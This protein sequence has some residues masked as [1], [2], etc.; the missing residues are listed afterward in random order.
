MTSTSSDPVVLRDLP[1]ED[2]GTAPTGSDLRSGSWTRLGDG[3][4]V[5]DPVT[6]AVLGPLAER[7]RA[8]ARAEGYAAGWA[9]GRRRAQE[10]AEQAAAE[11]AAAE[12]EAAVRLRADQ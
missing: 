8:A 11:R 1:T 9:E 3:G 6:E 4:V 2:V 12:H 7:V 10:A 5:G